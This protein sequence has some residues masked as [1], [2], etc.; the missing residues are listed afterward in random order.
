MTQDRSTHS[1]LHKQHDE[2]KLCLKL[3]KVIGQYE[4][5]VSNTANTLTIKIFDLQNRGKES[6]PSDIFV[7]CYGLSEVIHYVET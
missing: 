4:I 6:D 1:P 2:E 3:H 7:I 5:T